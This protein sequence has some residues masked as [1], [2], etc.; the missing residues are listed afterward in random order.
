LAGDGF[1]LTGSGFGLTGGGF[2]KCGQLNLK[3]F[4]QSYE[5]GVDLLNQVVRNGHFG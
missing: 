1:G 4:L 3:Q 2:L 5:T